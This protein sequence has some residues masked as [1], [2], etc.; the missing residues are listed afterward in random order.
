VKIRPGDVI[1][2]KRDHLWAKAGAIG[3]VYSVFTEWDSEDTI[4]WDMS[5]FFFKDQLTGSLKNMT[6]FGKDA[7]LHADDVEVVSRSGN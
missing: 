2:L 6:W 5:A 4:C 1:K 3:V 7:G